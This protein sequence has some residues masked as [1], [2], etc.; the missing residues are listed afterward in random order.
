MPLQLFEH[1]PHFLVQALQL[2]R[3]HTLL[4]S[5]SSPS[6]EV[7]TFGRQLFSSKSRYADRYHRTYMQ[8]QQSY[9][10]ASFQARTLRTIY[11][12][13]KD[14]R[15]S[16]LLFPSVRTCAQE[17]HASATSLA[18]PPPCCHSSSKSFHTLFVIHLTL[19]PTFVYNPRC[20]TFPP[21]HS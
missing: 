19:L 9:R 8:V 15:K 16:H 1:W 4:S 11:H 5:F 18:L 20:C 12:W 14:H 6:F 21:S 10:G 17:R 13:E 2:R 3:W 7:S